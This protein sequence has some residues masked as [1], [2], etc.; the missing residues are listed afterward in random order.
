MKILVDMNLSPRWSGLLS[1]AGWET[2]HWSAAGKPG[3]SDRE[4]LDYAAA[5]DYV[6]LTHDLDFGAILAVT[7]GKKPTV[8]QI[9]GE[10]VSLE[11]IG[12]QVVAA[13]FHVQAE[14]EAGA[15]LTIETERARLRL[16]P[17]RKE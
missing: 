11:G 13:L 1:E 9:R 16:L 5:N 7:H 2:K 14:L 8:V 12:G 15:L 4:I 17:L 10:D 3:A 6:V